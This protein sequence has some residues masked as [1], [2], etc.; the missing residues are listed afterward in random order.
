PGVPWDFAVQARGHHNTEKLGDDC[1]LWLEKHVARKPHFW[2]ARPK[3]EV[4]LGSDG[5]PELHLTPANPER[6][7]ELQVYQC[8]KTANNIER[9]WRDVPSERRGNTWL[10]KLPVMNVDD[11]VFSYANIHYDNDCVVSS[12]FEAVIPSQL[13]NAKATDRKSDAL[14]GGADRWSHAAPAEGVGGI[15]GFRP[16]DNHRGTLSG[17]FADPKWKAPKGA[18]LKFKFYCTQPQTL[19]LSG[20]R[21]ASEI[22]ITAS[23]EW[24]SMTIQASQLKHPAGFAMRDWSE[25]NAIGFKPKAG[26]D[27]TKVIFADFEWTAA[28]GK[29]DESGSM[30]MEKPIRYAEPIA[31]PVSPTANVSTVYAAITEFGDNHHG[32]V[33]VEDHG[34]QPGGRDGN[35]WFFFQT[36]SGGREAGIQIDMGQKLSLADGDSV[37]VSMLLGA[38]KGQTYTAPVVV[39]LTDGPSGRPLSMASYSPVYADGKDEVTF[40]FKE[41]L[42]DT[43][44]SL[45]VNISF[46]D[47]SQEF[48]QGLA[49]D[50]RVVQG[51]GLKGKVVA[52]ATVTTAG[53]FDYD[54]RV[55]GKE[56]LTPEPGPEPKLTGASIFGVRPGKPIRYCATAIGAKPLTFSAKGLPAGVAIDAKTGWVSGRAPKLKGDVNITITAT[57]AKGRDSR[58]LVLRVGDEICLT[59]PMGWNSWYVHSEGVSE[60]AIRD[61]ATAMKEKGLQSYGWSFVNIDDCWMGERD[62]VTKRIQANGKFDDMKQ[63]VDD[64]NS[65]GLKVGIYSTTWMSTFAGYIGGTAPNEAGDYSQYY[66]AERERQNPYQVFG[67]F[68]NGIKKC[69][70]TVGPVW[71][72]DR[73]AR[74]FADWGID[75]VKYDWLEWD[76][77]T[78]QQKAEGV[79]PKRNK[80]EKE[81]ENG[82]TQ[83]FYNDFRALDRDVVISLSPR[84]S[85]SEDAFVQEHCN[86]W[87]LTEDIHAHWDRMLAPFDDELVS[88]LALTRPGRYGDL[89]MLQIGPLG[90]PN[91]AEKVFR[92]S[93]LKPAEQYHQ[94]TLWCLLTQPMLLSC[95]VPTMDEFDLNLVSNHEVLAVN[96]D[97]LCKQG[98]RVTNKKGNYEIWAKD[99]ADGSKAVGL[100][101][102]SD[103]DQVLSIT[104][105]ELGIKGTIRDLWRQKNVGK[106]EGSFTANVSAHGVVFLKISGP[107][108][109]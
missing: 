56:V 83:R 47:E 70:A 26:S 33:G 90:R 109:G 73:D 67:R 77:V 20:G 23:D 58:T 30:A 107:K 2:P 63:M 1:K 57:N 49:R 45:R 15:E 12:D 18:S 39:T 27:I 53:A 28:K 19:L 51:M 61:M 89:D 29:A 36:G 55:W 105:Q 82:I 32:G 94:I 38:K 60:M 71:F 24:Q 80:R 10:A 42:R 6:I 99:L 98:Y 17:Q 35:N 21:F 106:L 95:N 93:P 104:A 54:G 50:I 46:R 86:L 88:R 72:V 3:S 69:I 25:I 5:V 76:L 74:Q 100:F 9:Y 41:G 108:T 68:P 31:K 78:E 7:K 64:V 11:Y 48:I 87:R 65:L 75:Y 14:P 4:R 91:A 101:N 34:G 37:Q 52:V 102:L 81:E 79:K 43:K 8:L 40:V 92:P 59:P 97:A 44:R 85:P 13:G 84:H 16:I 103:K 22:E 96:Q 62:P 66:L